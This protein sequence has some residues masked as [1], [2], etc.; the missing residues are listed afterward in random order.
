MKMPCG[1][2][3][4]PARRDFKEQEST[5]D[6]QYQCLRD[7]AMIGQ[8]IALALPRSQYVL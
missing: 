7:N 4:I 6:G 5:M 3:D 2:D 8:G 1:F